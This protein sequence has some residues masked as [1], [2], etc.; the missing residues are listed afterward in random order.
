MC[1]FVFMCVCVCVCVCVCHCICIMAYEGC[2]VCVCT[3]A[4]YDR[5]MFIIYLLYTL[6]H[7]CDYRYSN[8][9]LHASS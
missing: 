9:I 7:T 8:G 3:I 2:G 6:V 1:V 5:I 4:P